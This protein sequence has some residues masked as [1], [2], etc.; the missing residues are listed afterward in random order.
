[1]DAWARVNIPSVLEEIPEA[2]ILYAY[3]RPIYKIVLVATCCGEGSNWG[4]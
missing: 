2:T 3:S 1:M 4:G